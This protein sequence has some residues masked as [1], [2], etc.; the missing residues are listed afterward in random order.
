MMRWQRRRHRGLSR[1]ASHVLAGCPEGSLVV[2][3]GNASQQSVALGLYCGTTVEMLR[4]DPSDRLLVLKAG[5]ARLSV[6]RE[7]AENIFVA[8]AG[9]GGCG[10]PHARQLLGAI[11]QY[12]ALHG[13]VDTRT[14]AL[15]F[16]MEEDAMAG[17]LAFLAARGRV[18]RRE[19]PCEGGCGGC[20]G[21]SA[22][23]RGEAVV[24]SL[25]D[26][27]VSS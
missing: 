17:M 15:H 12:L 21:C 9:S 27:Q 25:A 4:N 3:T 10:R 6:P 5:E 19:L 18:C 7:W 8:P 13:P 23:G 1:E 24:W 16:E 20:R 22:M 2:V 14:L 26:G 11:R